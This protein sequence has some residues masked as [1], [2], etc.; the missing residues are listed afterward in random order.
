ME[1]F[2]VYELV[3]ESGKVVYVGKGSKDR[4][5][6]HFYVLCRP[7][8]KEYSASKYAKIR[9]LCAGE[10]MVAR[11]VFSSDD[12]TACL[13]KEQELIRHYGFENLANVASH[14][15]TG[16]KLKPEVGQAI[17]AKL[18]GRK[19]PPGV[20]AKIS[21][22]SKGRTNSAETRL[23]M[24]TAVSLA[25]ANG[26]SPAHLQKLSKSAVARGYSTK[27][28]E[29]M[30]QSRLGQSNDTSKARL[31]RGT[32]RVYGFI[33]P[34]G[35]A[36]YVFVNGIVG[37]CKRNGMPLTSVY[38]IFSKGSGECRGWEICSCNYQAEKADTN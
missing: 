11:K 10:K 8:L 5:K 2:Y 36:H 33:S 1:K 16:R 12:E 30:R 28:I 37:F 7:H 15:F 22:S 17:A 19:L 26:L 21:A 35:L 38:R 4:I 32:D 3:T 25:Y 23:K 24:S 29:A 9:A 6:H 27:A 34:D 14:A 18:R 20:R 31:S 13:L